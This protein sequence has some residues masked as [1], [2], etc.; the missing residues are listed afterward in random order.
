M[1]RELSVA[2]LIALAASV[3]LVASAAPASAP[4]RVDL[5]LD[6][7]SGKAGDLLTTG[8]VTASCHGDGATWNMRGDLWVSAK[9]ARPLPGPVAVGGQTFAGADATRTWMFNDRKT[10]NYLECQFK[11]R[12]ITKITVACYYTPGVT[13]PFA[14]QF[15]TIAFHGNRAFAVLQTRN[16]DG[17]GPCLRAHSCSEG[18]KTTFS[19]TQIKIV[20]GKTYWVNLHFDGETRTASVAAFDPENGL[21]QVGETAVAQ[22][23]ASNVSILAFGRFDNHGDNPEAATQSYFGQIVVDYTNAAFPLLPKTASTSGAKDTAPAATEKK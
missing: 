18:W 22:S 8:L 4:A 12:Q 14:N 1:R 6:M 21:S 13:I 16:D 3:A 11:D 17:K 7:E 10:H 23:S 2:L 5:Y 19:P 15:D 9:N 20:S